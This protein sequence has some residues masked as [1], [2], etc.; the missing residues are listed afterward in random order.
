[1]KSQS[2][3][4]ASAAAVKPRKAKLSMIDLSSVTF[5][6]LPAADKVFRVRTHEA[7]EGIDLTIENKRTYE[8][9][10]C[11]VKSIQDHG[12][13]IQ[14]PTEVFLST[15]SLAFEINN[16]DYKE[17]PEVDD[18]N[19]D[20]EVE[21]GGMLLTLTLRVSRVWKPEYSFKMVPVALKPVDT[22]SAQVRDI[23]EDISELKEIAGRS[24]RNFLSVACKTSC[25]YGQKVAWNGDNPL[26]SDNFRLSDDKTD[27]VVLKAGLYFVNTRFTSG[28]TSPN[29]GIALHLNGVAIAKCVVPYGQNGYSSTANVT[30]ILPLQ[31]GSVLSLINNTDRNSCTDQLSTKF[32][33]YEL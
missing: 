19:I 7:E 9:W 25:A 4:A 20:M 23:Q 33:M 24:S 26:M 3:T 12:P 5:P 18:P 28:N 11:T 21:D 6:S 29:E 13:D 30:E 27:I 22:L 8:Q 2:T 17:E 16:E 32:T 15:L 31:E 1:M 14:M 10:Q